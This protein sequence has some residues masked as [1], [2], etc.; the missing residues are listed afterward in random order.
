M[1]RIN[2]A[3]STAINGKFSTNLVQPWRDFGR[4]LD[5]RGENTRAHP[6]PIDPLVRRS[7]Y[8]CGNAIGARSGWMKIGG[9]G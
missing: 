3:T 8:R 4:K 1:H 6:I 9:I 2:R 7:E 5:E